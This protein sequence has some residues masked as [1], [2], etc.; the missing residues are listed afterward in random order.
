MGWIA[1][2]WRLIQPV[3]GVIAGLVIAAIIV[4]ASGFNPLTAYHALWTGATGLA[5]GPPQGVNSIRVGSFHLNL[6]LLAQSFA[7]ITPLIFTGTA[8]AVGLRAGMFNVG[9]QGQMTMG[10]LFAAVIGEIGRRNSA[11]GGSIYPAVHVALVI[12]GGAAAGALWGAIPGVLKATR[13][14]HEVISTIMLNFVALDIAQYLVTH[15]LHD[16]TPNN[17][18]AES[19]LMANTS[20]LWPYVHGSSFTA[21]L[22]IALCCAAIVVLVIRRTAAGYQIRAV[23]LGA[24][25]ARANGVSVGK[26]LVYT[27]MLSGAISGLAGAIEV[28]G[29]HH[30]YVGGVAGTYGF[31]G[32]AV[33]LLGNLS[34]LGVIVGALLFGSLA[35]GS[36]YMETTTRV[37][38]PISEIVQAIVIIFVGMRFFK[39][40]SLGSTDSLQTAPPAVGQRDRNG[41][42]TG[43]GPVVNL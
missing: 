28:M 32:I 33:A 26:V 36:L 10:A 13:G 24:E 2:K 22:P 29:I 9:A 4:A 1:G 43:E 16:S 40:V 7:K 25:A 5:P 17:M 19:P 15:S 12:V 42:E 38:A 14:V 39:R 18:A 23:G 35:S 27:M 37:P 20:W 41:F 34:G 6:F 31:D 8:V 30:R 3:V 11:G 21:G